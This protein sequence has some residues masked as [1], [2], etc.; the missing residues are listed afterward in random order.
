MPKILLTVPEGNLSVTRPVVLDVLRQLMK[1]T[2]ISDK[3]TVF[4]P[5]EYDRGAQPNS[6]ISS[7]DESNMFP[8]N[9]RVSIEVEE[10]Y[11]ADRIL[12]EATYQPEQLFIF[13]DPLIETAIKPAYSMS[14]IVINIKYRALDKTQAMRWR[15]DL[16]ARIG[17]RKDERYH[18]VSY[19]YLIPPEFIV[20]LREIHRMREAVAGY[21]ENFDEWFTQHLTESATVFTTL[22]GT[23]GQWGVTQTQQRIIGYFDFDGTPEV[24]S[25]EDD[26]DTWTISVAYKFSFEKPTACVMAYPLMVHNQLMSDKF[27]P[28]VPQNEPSSH[29]RSYSQ[30]MNALSFFE[31]GMDKSALQLDGAA[32]PWFDEFIPGSVTTKTKRVVTML[33]ALDPSNMN[34]LLTADEV[35]GV[36]ID[37]VVLAFMKKEAPYMTGR[38]Q[39]IFQLDFYRGIGMLPQKLLKIDSALQVTTTENLSLRDYHHVRLSI[40][41]DLRL[42]PPAAI[43]RLRENG[44]AAIIILDYLAPWLKAANLLPSLL[45][46]GSIA[47]RDLTVVI[48]NINAGIISLGNRQDGYQFN[49]V[50]TMFVQTFPKE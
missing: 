4:Y 28:T 47:M 6:Q 32:I 23:Q 46:N 22:A 18:E 43:Q 38:Y 5:G 29:V 41:E 36:G 21:N 8:F 48:D 27:R 12:S 16:R 25:K 44:A 34:L 37:P 15:D 9:E 35:S 40:V 45:V 33:T 7:S 49:T 39:S 26:G 2:G 17:M 31:K 14:D 13:R 3:T 24:G 10:S 42:L 20:I 11:N 19:H 1:D 30:T 50:G